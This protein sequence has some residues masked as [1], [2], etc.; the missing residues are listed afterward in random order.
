[1]TIAG[2]MRAEIEEILEEVETLEHHFHTEQLCLGMGVDG[3]LADG[4][5]TSFQLTTGLVNV[6]GAE[7]QLYNGAMGSGVLLD[8]DKVFVTQAQRID[9]TYLVE[10][11]AGTTTFAAATRIASFYYRSGSSTVESVPFQVKSPRVRG[12][13]K[14]WARTKSTYAT[15]ST[16]DILFESHKYPSDTGDQVP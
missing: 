10:F 8:L 13:L 7:V 4:S 5:L 9:E 11:W 1:M 3:Y 16:I 15:A 6:F 12:D 2:P 14:I